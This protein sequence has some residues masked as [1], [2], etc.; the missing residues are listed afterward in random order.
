MENQITAQNNTPQ[1]SFELSY[2]EKEITGIIYHVNQLTSFA[3]SDIQIQDWSI[4]INDFYP[5]L[6]LELLKKI[7]RK[8]K[9]GAY[10]WDSRQGIQ[11][12]CEILSQYRIFDIYTKK[13][14]KEAKDLQDEF[15]K[16]TSNSQ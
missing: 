1:K 12:I 6:D 4:T 15:Y 7:I 3:L 10:K 2:K 11:N 16:G 13:E 9:V 14:E 8:Y 5:D